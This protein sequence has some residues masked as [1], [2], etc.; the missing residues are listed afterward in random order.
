[1][2]FFA[3]TRMSCI[4]MLKSEVHFCDLSEPCIDFIFFIS[5]LK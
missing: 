1:V 4:L 2:K 3:W 5:Y